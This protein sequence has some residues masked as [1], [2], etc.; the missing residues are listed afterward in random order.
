MKNKQNP[1]AWTTKESCNQQSQE[2]FQVFHYLAKL[3]T[4]PSKIWYRDKGPYDV[5]GLQGDVAAMHTR[6]KKKVV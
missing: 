4:R 2:T 1:A 6:R 3:L 5:P